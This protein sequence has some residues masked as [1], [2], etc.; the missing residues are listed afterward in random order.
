MHCRMFRVVKRLN[1]F[2]KWTDYTPLI[3]VA[4]A[5]CGFLL[6]RAVSDLKGP[7][8]VGRTGWRTWRPIPHAIIN[9]KVKKKA[10]LTGGPNAVKRVAGYSAA[11]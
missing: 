8:C 10:A 3:Y 2:V 4:R 6:V 5:V 7:N 11:D 1:N 9:K